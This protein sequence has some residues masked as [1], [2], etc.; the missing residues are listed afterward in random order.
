MNSTNTQEWKKLKE[1]IDKRG[2]CGKAVVEALREHYSIYD[3]KML[4]WLGTLYDPK[5]GGFYYSKSGRFTDDSRFLPDIE[6]TNQATNILISGGVIGDMNDLPEEMREKMSEFICS[7]QS[8]FDGYIYHPQ[9]G[10]NISDSR[11]GRDLTWAITM[12]KKLN[13][14]LPYKTPNERISEAKAH[15]KTEEEKLKTTSSFPSHLKSKENLLEYL[16][17]FDWTHGGYFAGNTVA[18]QIGQIVSAGFGDLVCDYISSAQNKENG[19][20][21][22]SVGFDSVNGAFKISYIY[23]GS[24]RLMPYA[25]QAAM[26]AMDCIT[27]F[28]EETAHVC[29]LFNTWYTVINLVGNMRRF[30]DGDARKEADQI[31]RELLLRAPDAIRATT[32]KISEF[33]K[34]D[35]SF[36][37]CKDRTSCYSQGALVAVPNPDGTQPNEGDVNATSI[38]STSLTS[39]IYGALDLRDF[40]VKLFDKEDLKIFLDAIE[41]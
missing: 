21:S 26:A 14:N 9:W 12:A 2:G 34:S 33:Q 13:I 30:G 31:V 19:L 32:K 28:E 10:K 6:S 8:D 41:K 29:S 24:K 27:S 37:Y 25:G 20:W 4:T 39:N 5:H 11:R 16:N 38:S 23:N 18:A 22:N 3:K 40:A 15:N 1:E 36:S 17:G 35:G 7:L